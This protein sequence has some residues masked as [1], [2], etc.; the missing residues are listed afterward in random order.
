MVV[1]K[2]P[3]VGVLAT[4]SELL[5][6]DEPLTQGKIRNSNAYML[7]SQVEQAGG[8]TLYFGKL[9][10]DLEKSVKLLVEAEQDPA[11][12]NPLEYAI[13]ARKYIAEHT[14]I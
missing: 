5:E 4:G 9:E 3:L 1:E 12:A 10:D 8:E 6:I 13:K 14:G 7:L 11:K 2:K